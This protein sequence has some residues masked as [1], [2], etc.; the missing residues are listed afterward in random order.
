MSSAAG[1]AA[2]TCAAGQVVGTAV[3]EGIVAHR[4]AVGSL[5]HADRF[6]L[7]VG[8]SSVVVAA[9][10][11]GLLHGSW[12]ARAAAGLDLV[13]LVFAGRIFAGLTR[14]E[15]ALVG[16]LTALVTGIVIGTI[17]ARRYTANS[18]SHY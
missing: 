17:L 5:P 11:V 1:G 10:T 18:P 9:I 2:I 4:I 12:L 16:R 7:G 6:L 13:L 14:L 3:T 15:V 8:P